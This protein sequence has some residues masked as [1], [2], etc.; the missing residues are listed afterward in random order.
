MSLSMIASLIVSKTIVDSTETFNLAMALAARSYVSRRT[1]ASFSALR[2]GS[3]GGAPKQDGPATKKPSAQDDPYPLPLQHAKHPL[4]S[5]ESPQAYMAHPLDGINSVPR[6]PESDLNTQRARLIYQ[7]RKRGTLETGLLISTF[8]NPARLEKMG[9]AELNELDDLLKV[10]EWTL[11]YWG[12]GKAQPP[13]DSGFQNST[14]LSKSFIIQELLLLRDSLMPSTSAN[15][16]IPRTLQESRWQ[17]EGHAR[18]VLRAL[19]CLC[20]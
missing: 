20:K 8:F 10:P 14:L 15:R 3:Q 19:Y 2:I 11:Y 18:L 12:I 6:G 13:E 7:T 17:D 9:R 16:T 1:F 5:D 4:S